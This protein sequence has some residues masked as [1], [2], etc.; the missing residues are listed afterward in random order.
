MI[1]WI[2]VMVTATIQAA[3]G[4][5]TVLTFHLER[6]DGKPVEEGDIAITSVY[7]GQRK[8]VAP[9][10]NGV[11]EVVVPYGTYLL[12]C[13]DH[14]PSAAATAFRVVQVHSERAK[15]FIRLSGLELWQI[16]GSG[17]FVP[18][19]ISGRISRAQAGP[20]AFVRACRV[21]DS[22]CADAA[23]DN[24][25]SFEMTV[26]RLGVY[27]VSVIV[28][29]NVVATGDFVI[30]RSDDKRIRFTMPAEK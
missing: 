24:E 8:F 16:I 12:Q 20:G 19:T 22:T 23:V 25:G 2:L 11:A 27:Q 14:M 17:E 30:S 13:C 28:N 18:W 1:N 6:P 4:Q 3:Q 15:V 9:V 10:L 29:G 7:A 5:T 26:T 21:G